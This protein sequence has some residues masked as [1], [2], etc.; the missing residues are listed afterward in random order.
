MKSIQKTN[1]KEADDYPPLIFFKKKS[2]LFGNW[3]KSSIFAP[4]FAK[5]ICDDIDW[6]MV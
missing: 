6:S 2:F 1:K 5:G 4:S 3:Y